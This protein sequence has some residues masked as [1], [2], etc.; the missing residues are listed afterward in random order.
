MLDDISL[1]LVIRDAKNDGR[2]AIQILRAHYLGTSKPRIISLYT[3][4]TTL[5]KGSDETALEYLI[6]AENFASALNSAGEQVSDGL[7]IAMVLKGLPKEYQSFSTVII[8]RT[9][10][11]NFRDFKIAFRNFEESEKNKYD[12]ITNTVMKVNASHSSV[13]C[14]NCG[15]LGHKKSE[16]PKKGK[17]TSRWCD[18]HKSNS[19]DTKFCRRNTHAKTVNSNDNCNSDDGESFAFNL[20]NVNSST[21]CD[22]LLVDCGA[23]SH[24]L[25]DSS[26]FDNYDEKFDSAAHMIELADGTRTNGIVT[27]RGDAS[28]IIEDSQGFPRKVKLNKAL[29]I[30]SYSQNIFSVQCATEKGA[31]FNFSSDS[32]ELITGNGTKFNIQKHGKLYYLN[33][34]KTNVSSQRPITE[35]HKVLG[36]CNVADIFHLEKFVH[37][38]KITDKNF[39]DCSTCN[40]GKMNQT[41]SKSP[42]SRATSPLELVH[43]DL[44]GPLSPVTKE[45]YKFVITFVDDYSGLV[46]VYCLKNKTGATYALKKFLA[47]SSPYGTVKRLR[48]DNGTEFTSGEFQEVIISNKIKHEFSCPSSPHQ[49]GTAERSWRTIFNMARCLIFESNLSKTLWHYAVKT[50]AYIRNRCYSQRIGKTPYEL[51]TTVRPN[52]SNMHVFGSRCFAYIHGHKTKFEPR[53]KEGIF[54]GYDGN[55]TA[56]LVYFPDIGVKKSRCVNFIKSDSFET[57]DNIAVPYYKG[58]S[59]EPNIEPE[60]TSKNQP[61]EEILSDVKSGNSSKESFSEEITS[62]VRRSTRN[63]KP[64]TYLNDYETDLELDVTKYTVDYCYKVNYIPTCYSEAILSNESDNWRKAMTEEIDALQEND[65]YDIVT[66]PKDVKVI[67]GRWVYAIKLGPDEEVKYKARYVAKGFSQRKE[68]DYFE[69]FSPTARITSIRLL[70]QISIED[71]LIIH[72]LDFKSAYLN[73][74]IDCELYLS[75]PQGFVKFNEKGE[76]LALRLKKSIYGLKQSARNWNNVLKSFL[77]SNNFKQSMNDYCIFIKFLDNLKLIVLIWVDDLL[78]CASNETILNN[79]KISLKQKF[80]VKDLGILNWFLGI[81][82]KFF[83]NSI[84]MDQSKCIEN[85]LDKFN[86]SD[87]KPKYV[88]C[89][90]SVNNLKTSDSSPLADCNLYRSIVGC[91]IYIMSNTRPDLCFIVTKLSQSMS[92]PTFADLNVAKSVLRYLKGTIHFKLK[93]EKSVTNLKLLGFSDSDWG[94]SE[95]RKSISGYCFLLNEKGPA[96]SWKSKK[97]SIVALSSCE[98]EYVALSE[99]AREAIFLQQIYSDIKGMYTEPVL[100]M[101]DNQGAMQLAANPIHHQRSKHIDIKFHFIR[102]LL[103]QGKIEIRYVPTNENLADIFTK[104]LNKNKLSRFECLRGL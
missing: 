48:S 54:V 31:K 66:P 29:L 8:Q 44:A 6:R 57:E 97:Q 47:D 87:C 74:P 92:N 5:R 72:Q 28:I 21:K 75:Q 53:S 10:T 55:S 94:G 61:T 20:S 26:L 7:L 98:A 102:S 99:A 79:F 36:H 50:S 88:P 103:E 58:D 56:F 17:K 100:I 70:L 89:D 19:H 18:F 83:D 85:I 68:I 101:A 60:I 46:M 67:D 16:C 13:K 73:A 78:I 32:A 4:L 39:S 76:K 15:A 45:N 65:T 59:S 77:L 35:W 84:T 3:E 63:R 96:I 25:T 82:F 22:K 91:L 38:M 93:F 64:P 49:N 12:G 86:M 52:I 1:S 42:D 80:R 41:I 104:S 69:T 30:P 23:T 14:Y 62:D 90:V 2:K 71:N 37:G 9:D 27:G 51:F 95:D 24:I 81:Q 43:C 11:L 40:L 34:V 33:N